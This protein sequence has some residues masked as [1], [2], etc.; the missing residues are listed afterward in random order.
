[1]RAFLRIP[2]ALLEEDKL[3]ESVII[4]VESRKGIRVD[5]RLT[6]S[7]EAVSELLF[8][9]H[10][11]VCVCVHRSDFKKWLENGASFLFCA[12]MR[13]NTLLE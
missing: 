9:K 3:A 7:S 6:V 12:E 13:K 8:F 1:M 11:R 4:S 5:Q 10:R 2:S